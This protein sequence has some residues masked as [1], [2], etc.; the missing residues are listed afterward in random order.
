M[1]IPRKTLGFLAGALA[2]AVGVPLAQGDPGGPAGFGSVGV[3]APGNVAVRS[4]RV[5]TTAAVTTT[6]ATAAAAPP[7]A[8]AAP[9]PAA[10]PVAVAAAPGPTAMVAALPAGCAPSGDVFKCGTAYYKPFMSGGTI[11]YGVVPG[12]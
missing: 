11:V 12:P 6:A 5:A 1:R 4:A 2:I 3:G 9:P 8:A 10:A 7:P